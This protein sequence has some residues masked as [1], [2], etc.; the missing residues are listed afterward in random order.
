MWPS[1]VPLRQSL[2]D[3]PRDREFSTPVTATVAITDSIVSEIVFRVEAERLWKHIRVGRRLEKWVHSP[4]FLGAIRGCLGQ[5]GVS[6]G[7]YP[8]HFTTEF[9]GAR[10]SLLWPWNETQDQ[11]WRDPVFY[12]SPAPAAVDDLNPR[13]S[14]YLKLLQILLCNRID[15]VCRPVGDF[16]H[17][18]SLVSEPGPSRYRDE[19]KDHII[20]SLGE[21]PGSLSD[22]SSTGCPQ[23]IRKGF[24]ECASYPE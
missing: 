14:A 21:V 12:A 5:L 16:L 9:G 18:V 7:E 1:G 23:D 4:P 22:T 15:A 10:I 17:R 13:A 6:Q 24:C 19:P 8:D 11:W 2:S 20:E 3:R